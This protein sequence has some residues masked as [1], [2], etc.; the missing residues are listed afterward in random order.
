MLPA[1]LVSVLLIGGDDLTVVTASAININV[2][3]ARITEKGELETAL[4]YPKTIWETQVSEV[5]YSVTFPDGV[6]ETRVRTETR[7]VPRTVVMETAEG[8][9][10]NGS[11][12]VWREEKL[13]DDQTALNLLKTYRRVVIVAGGDLDAP[14]NSRV[15]S[16]FRPEVII[17]SVQIGPAP[18]AP[19][20]RTPTPAVPPQ[21]PPPAFAPT[22][23]PAPSGSDA[24]APFSTPQP[25]WRDD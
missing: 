10:K 6:V 7:Q 20:S 12:K 16:M 15:L 24:V 1:L 21:P 11:F 13:L 18:P 5:P 2:I 17:V 14:A 4:A 22:T 3:S 8:K 19:P 25:P 9:Y 23:V